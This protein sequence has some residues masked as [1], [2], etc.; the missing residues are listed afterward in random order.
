M[1]VVR[2][3]KVAKLDVVHNQL[4][5]IWNGL[6]VE[7]QSNIDPPDI[8]TTLN[9]FLTAMDRRKHQWW[10]KASRMRL[11][12]SSNTAPARSTQVQIQRS[13][14]T[15]Q[16]DNQRGSLRP[17]NSGN[18]N[19]GPRQPQP[20]YRQNKAY[21]SQYQRYQNQSYGNPNQGYQAYQSCQPYQPRPKDQPQLQ[22]PPVPR[23]ITAGPTLQPNGSG[24]RQF[25]NDLPY[26]NYC[27]NAYPPRQQKAY[28]ATVAEDT[29]RSDWHD[30]DR[31]CYHGSE[32][33]DTGPL[34]EGK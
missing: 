29:D 34:I 13:S 6:D 32:S 9:Q 17:Y 14:N 28:H 2:A 22:A 20:F 27:N 25:G 19:Y 12:S 33:F 18:Q 24:S 4:D 23:H 30:E 21:N 8:I 5:I 3:A 31:E 11:R 16:N 26:N 15:G 7:F 10:A 1:A